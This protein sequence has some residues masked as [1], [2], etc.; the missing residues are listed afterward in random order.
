MIKLTQKEKECFYGLV[1]YPN[2]NDNQLAEKVGLK[3]STI[4]SIRNKLKRNAFYFPAAIPC[5][6]LIGCE[7]I[8]VVYGDLAGKEDKYKEIFEKVA[9]NPHVGYTYFNATNF[10]MVMFDKN[11]TEFRKYFDEFLTFF[12]EE[13][14]LKDY[15]VEHFPLDIS[16]FYRRVDFSDIL[17][18][19]F[20][21]DKCPVLPDEPRPKL[22]KLSNKEKV[23]L[24]ALVQYPGETDTFIAEK[25]KVARPTISSIKKKLIDKRL[26]HIMNVP[27]IHKMP[28]ELLVFTVNKFTHNVLEIPK[29]SWMKDMHNFL[30]LRSTREGFGVSLFE[31]YSVYHE[32]QG[33]FVEKMENMKCF[34]CKPS[35]IIVSLKEEYKRKFDFSGLVNKML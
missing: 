30:M 19:M 12:E 6:R 22:I 9:K 5:L 8:S 11:Y 25:T 33:K 7:L 28:F 21:F 17:C 4:T 2:L 23:V 24:K 13:E 1:K 34:S 10:F 18:H 29:E 27:N 20:G 14:I 26:L 16:R 3:R 15:K 31:D 35:T 32:L